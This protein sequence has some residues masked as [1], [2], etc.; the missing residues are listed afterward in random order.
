[1]F[2]EAFE[3]GD[4]VSPYFAG[5]TP[6]RWAALHYA[7]HARDALAPDES[8][9]WKQVLYPLYGAYRTLLRAHLPV[10]V[11]T[12]SQLEQGRLDGYRVLFLPAADR[13]TPRDASGGRGIQVARR[14]GDRATGILA[15]GTRRTAGW[16]VL[17]PN[18]WRNCL[19][20]SLPLPCA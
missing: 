1:M 11:V 13:L 14:T 3:L 6:T 5:T 18:S 7:E 4:R 9:Q 10:G 17:R 15:D 8:G 16:N 19:R 2:D 12:D 20:N